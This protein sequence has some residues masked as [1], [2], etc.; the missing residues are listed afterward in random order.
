M[1]KT[2]LTI[3]NTDGGFAS[4]TSGQQAGDSSRQVFVQA[5]PA[6]GFVFDRWEI[7]TEPA[8]LSVFAAV[9]SNPVASIREVCGTIDQPSTYQAVARELFTDGTMLY[10][11]AQGRYPAPTGYWGVYGGTYYY[12]DGGRL[13]ALQTCTYGGGGGGTGGT[14]GTGDGLNDDGTV[15]GP[16]GGRDEIRFT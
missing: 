6:E 13:P 5:Y 12:W 8:L 2:T 11:D 10:L 3:D 14:G 16:G 1:P 9:A 7:F 4:I 15:D